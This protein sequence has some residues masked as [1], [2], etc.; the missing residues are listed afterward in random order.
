MST[1]K[2][3]NQ[4]RHL[5]RLTASHWEKIEHVFP[6]QE[7]KA[8]G[9]RQKSSDREILEAILWLMKWDLNWRD[10]SEEYHLS[11]TTCWR[12]FNEWEEKKLWKKIWTAFL[13]GLNKRERSEWEEYF[14]R[15]KF[16]VAVIKKEN[17][18]KKKAVSKKQKKG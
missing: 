5:E 11:P 8:P 14:D 10:V 17:V 1:K 12:R 6:P 18:K 3:E 13:D 4:K 7:P 9:G 16:P 2:E 15:G